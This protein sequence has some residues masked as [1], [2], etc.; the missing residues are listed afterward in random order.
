ML[1]WSGLERATTF[2]ARLN[3]RVEI[4]LGMSRYWMSKSSGVMDKTYKRTELEAMTEDPSVLDM[5]NA[6]QP[7]FGPLQDKIDAIMFPAAEV[8]EDA[9]TVRELIGRFNG[10]QEMYALQTG[11]G[12]TRRL[13]TP[14][15]SPLDPRVLAF[16][17]QYEP[18]AAS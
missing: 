1:G 15:F 11:P 16:A 13:R 6:L 17:E 18:P 10:R 5:I 3:G 12:F 14:S 2:T 4:T 7:A 8:A 9:E